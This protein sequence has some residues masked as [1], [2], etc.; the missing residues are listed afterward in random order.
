MKK[1]RIYSIEFGRKFYLTA[2]FE[3]TEDKSQAEL[4]TEQLVNLYCDEESGLEFEELSEA[5]KMRMTGAAML[6]GL[7]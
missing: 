3:P 2:D 6:P 1:Y 7:E 5:E 4:F